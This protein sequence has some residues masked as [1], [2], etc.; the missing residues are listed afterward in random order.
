M[1]LIESA[2]E[3]TTGI[4]DA[5]LAVECVAIV[6]WLLRSPATDRWRTMLWSGAFSLLGLASL[7]GALAHSLTMPPSVRAALWKPLYLC[8]GIVVALF[9][10][11]ALADWRGQKLGR[12]LVPWAVAVGALFFAATQLGSG[13]FILFVLYEG[14][15]MSAALVVYSMLAATRRLQG[16]AL[17]ALA[18]LLNLVAAGVQASSLSVHLLIPFDHNGLFHLVQMLS[19]ATLA[20]GLRL[21][22]QTHPDT[23]SMNPH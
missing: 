1:H 2:S 18:V 4:T 22:L 21:G 13:A 12:R 23:E 5:L 10:V 19:L 7:L 6:A 15:A 16:A 11:G 17:I 14:L 20:W 8:L 3:L 9:V